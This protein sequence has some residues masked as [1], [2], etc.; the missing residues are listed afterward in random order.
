MTT[1][2][3]LLDRL[4]TTLLFTLGLLLLIA[5]SLVLWWAT[6]PADVHGAR[7]VTTP[8]SIAPTAASIPTTEQPTPDATRN[9]TPSVATS[10]DLETPRACEYEDASDLAPGES[11]TWNATT[12]GNG[13][14]QSFYATRYG[15]VIMYVYDDFGD[16]VW[17][18]VFGA[19]AEDQE[20]LE[21]GDGWSPPEPAQN[22]PEGD[23][24]QYCQLFDQGLTT[25]DGQRF[26][27]G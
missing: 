19:D 11:C 5:Q 18:N 3:S 14:G 1:T 13:E 12:A 23:W 21:V 7:E 2:R 4:F 27:D 8:I 9:L 15:D 10:G 17:T 22:A 16:A 25:E 26:C 20:V 24:D 6:S